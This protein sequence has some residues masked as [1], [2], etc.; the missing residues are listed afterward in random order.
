[1]PHNVAFYETKDADNPILPP[2]ETP[3]FPG[4]R[5]VTYKLPALKNG[6]YFF[7]CDAHAQAMNGD[8]VVRSR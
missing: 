1:V 8:L 6:T 2:T 3:L 4:P 5:T 7:R